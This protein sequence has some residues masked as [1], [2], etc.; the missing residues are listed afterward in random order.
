K[1]EGQIYVFDTDRGRLRHTLRGHTGRV[2][3]LSFAPAHKGRP[4]LLVSAAE[5]R[6]EEGPVGEVR[7]WDADKGAAVAEV[8]GLPNEEDR[9][10]ALAAWHTSDGPGQ[11]RVAIAAG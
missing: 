3:S 9:P 11:L 2:R 8:A 1:D 6:N 10:P 5:G 4:A 7:V